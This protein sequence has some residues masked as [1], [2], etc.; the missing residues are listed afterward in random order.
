[1]TCH[2]E[3]YAEIPLQNFVWCDN[4]TQN[5]RFQSES[6]FRIVGTFNQFPPNLEFII[7]EFGW[8][9]GIFF[10]ITAFTN[11]CRYIDLVLLLNNFIVLG[12]IFHLRISPYVNL[13]APRLWSLVA[14]INTNELLYFISWE[15]SMYI[16]HFEGYKCSLAYLTELLKYIIK[17]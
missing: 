14:L 17:F 16:F 3:K 8:W 11:I 2:S 4:K 13:A 10:G 5:A 15:T 9:R 6:E 7:W 12:S 1:M